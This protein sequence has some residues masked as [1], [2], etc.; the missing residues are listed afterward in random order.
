MLAKLHIVMVS[1]ALSVFH[2]FAYL[3]LL[4]Y[5]DVHIVVS[6][7]FH[8][9]MCGLRLVSLLVCPYLCLYLYIDVYMQSGSQ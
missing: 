2:M 5:V 7:W 1:Y 3:R 4:R 6:D 8:D 9:C